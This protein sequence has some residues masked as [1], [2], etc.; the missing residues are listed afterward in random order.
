VV[1]AA[2]KANVHE[3]ILALPQGYETPIQEGGLGLSG[4]QKQ[5]IGL[6]RALFGAPKLLVLDEPNAHLDAEGE[7]ALADS[8]AD[9]KAQGCTIVI[10]AHRLNPLSQVDRVVVLNRGNL[11]MDGPRSE[12]IGR[13]CTEVVR[14]FAPQP[15]E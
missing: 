13:V 12:V 6:A 11:E 7:R 14:S 2:Q 9:L 4:G 10:V 8:L 1:A 3:L 5:R 15:A